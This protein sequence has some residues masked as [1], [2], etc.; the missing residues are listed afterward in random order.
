MDT[1]GVLKRVLPSE[2]YYVSI[3][4]NPDGR[5]QGFFQTVEELATAC[6]RL[7]RAGN[8]TY[9]AISSFCTKENRKQE[10]VNKTKVIAIDV[11]CGDGKPFADWREGLKA[12]QDYIIRMKLPKPM[13]VGS[14]NGLHVYWVL[15]KELEPDDWKPIANAVKASALDKGFK[16]DAG[17]IANS[18][19]VLRPIGTHN[20]K[21]G[22]EVKLL[23][24]ADPVTPEELSAKLHDYVLS[25]GPLQSR[26]TSDNSLLNNLSA[27][28]EFPPSISSSIY[29]KCQQV[30]YAVDNQDSVT[31]PVWYNAIGIA[32]YCIDPEDTARRWSE[33]YP[34]YSEEATMSK[35]R[36]W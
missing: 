30:K 35:L 27:T 28:V 31:E 23:I 19:L 34:A 29:N 11:D 12:L 25:T 14:G 2:G 8:N 32:A 7:D 26:Q 17:L 9:F 3:V 10:N 13:V 24:D 36:H 33:N 18:S 6:T 21:N 20:P 15:T 22:K 4:V 16:A 5:K 1:L